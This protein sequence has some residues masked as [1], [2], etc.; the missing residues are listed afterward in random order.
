MSGP[1]GALGGESPAT[2]RLVRLRQAVSRP[3]A[4]VTAKANGSL[5]SSAD[6]PS[7]SAS[8][9]YLIFV[10]GVG[11]D[12]ASKVLLAP[13]VVTGGKAGPST[14]EPGVTL[15]V[16]SL[17]EEVKPSFPATRD[18][19][20]AADVEAGRARLVIE[21]DVLRVMAVKNGEGSG[22]AWV[23]LALGGAGLVIALLLVGLARRRR[24]TPPPA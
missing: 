15:P 1:P 23:W 17:V 21:G 4:D 14:P 10:D 8:G 22:G 16:P 2:V 5:R 20:A 6:F 12:G 11:P 13:V 19:S 3:L 18:A 7:T 9:I 24:S